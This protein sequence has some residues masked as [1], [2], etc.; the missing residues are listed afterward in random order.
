MKT[1][2]LTTLKCLFLIVFF[3]LSSCEK[4]PIE[5]TNT[6]ISSS[7]EDNVKTEYIDLFNSSEGKWVNIWYKGVQI[8]AFEINEGYIYS[9]DVLIPKNKASSNYKEYN[10]ISKTGG[11]ITLLS[12]WPKGQ[13]IYEIDPALPNQNRVTNAISHWTN[14][15]NITFKLRGSET[16]YVR[17]TTGGGCYSSSI[18]MDGG[19]QIVGLSNS[20]STGNVIHEI[21]HV[22]GLWHEHT[23]SDRNN[24]IKVLWNNIIDTYEPQFEIQNTI[25]YGFLDFGSIMMYP[26]NSSFSSN[27]NPTMTKLDGS[28]WTAQRSA[29]ST[30]DINGSNALYDKYNCYGVPT[31]FSHNTYAD[32]RRVKYNGKVYSKIP[33]SSNDFRPYFVTNR[34]SYVAECL[35]CADFNPWRPGPH[36]VNSYVSYN[37]ELYKNIRFIIPPYFFTPPNQIPNTWEKVECN[38]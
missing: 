13:V 14:N 17:F 6:V 30:N 32:G 24:K 10:G 3:T 23:R 22:I 21:G 33:G 2:T 31:F 4:T 27:G 34:W 26:S 7:T 9:G 19:Q 20:C 37:G 12:R 15:T 5:E 8:K 28:T 11:S 16:D 38:E 36:A 25:N 29:L 1:I 35:N 18:G